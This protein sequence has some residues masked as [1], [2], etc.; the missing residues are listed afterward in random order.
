MNLRRVVGSLAVVIA[1]F[2]TSAAGGAQAQTTEVRGS[3]PPAADGDV[4][5]D[6]D[7]H[8]RSV[9]Y[10]TVPKNAHV[11]VSG[12]NQRGGTRIV[13]TNIPPHPQAGVTYRNVRIQYQAT[14]RFVDP[15]H[16]SP[17]SSATPAA[18]R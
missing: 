5:L 10:Q 7:V 9:R 3:P 2:A 17:A 18:H 13:R 16:P 15:A 12:V 6:A 8:I 11:T 1:V 14:S 4:V